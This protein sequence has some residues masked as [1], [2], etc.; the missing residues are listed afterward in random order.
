MQNASSFQTALPFS[1]HLARNINCLAAIGIVFAGFLCTPAT[2]QGN[3]QSTDTSV[4]QADKRVSIDAEDA[5]LSSVLTMLMKSVGANYTLDSSLRALRV[6]AH[7]HDL[8][9]K[10]ALDVLLRS[11]APPVTYRL[12][13]GVYQFQLK[14]ESALPEP[15][16]V[17][18]VSDTSPQSGVHHLQV[19]R[20]YF[21]D[22]A[23]AALILGGIPIRA[24]GQ[25]Y[26]LVDPNKLGIV[27]VSSGAT[28]GTG[29]AGNGPAGTNGQAAN[30]QTTNGQNTA[31]P[32]NLFD[33]LW[34]VNA[35]AGF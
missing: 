15:D 21:I 33:Y 4:A 34:I 13:D 26:G 32:A 6:T 35:G 5:T 29:N 24:T 8:R 17:G 27:G 3:G 23:E 11:V 28:G 18:P 2:A 7:L 16:A 19:A 1:R 9:L 25:T 22:A 31:L 12:E 20:V 14:S 30:G 10:T